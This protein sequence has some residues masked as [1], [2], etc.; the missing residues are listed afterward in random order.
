M[1]GLVPSSRPQLVAFYKSKQAPWGTHAPGIGLTPQSVEEMTTQVSAAEAAH[2]R[3][4]EARSAAIAATAN[5][6]AIVDA[7]ASHGSTMIGAIRNFA[8]GS[9]DPAAVHA[10]A[11]IPE[12]KTP[13]PVP[14]PGTPFKVSVV[15]FEDGSLQL[16]W[17]CSNPTDGGGVVYEIHRRDGTGAMAHVGTV[18]KRKFV[19]S[20][21]PAGSSNVTYSIT[22]VRST[23]KGLPAQFKVQFGGGGGG[24]AGAGAGQATPMI[25]KAA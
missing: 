21:I 24:G 20:T 3:M 10:L 22:A 14:A 19:D 13:A 5:Y 2:N 17:R 6:H 8:R 12:R 9:A 7:L 18:G 1:A 25:R 11:Q 4:L 16:K 15:L 23:R